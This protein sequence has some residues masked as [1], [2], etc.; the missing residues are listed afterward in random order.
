MQCNY[1][2]HFANFE[3]FKQFE[4]LENAREKNVEFKNLQSYFVPFDTF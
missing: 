1:F 2:E 3:H 4:N